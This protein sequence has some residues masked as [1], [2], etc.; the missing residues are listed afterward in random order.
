MYTTIETEQHYHIATVWLNRPDVRNAFNDTMI[1]E[2]I[3]AFETLGSDEVVRVITLRGRGKVF[4]A[5]ADLKWMKATATSGYK[6]SLEENRQLAQCFQT[7]YNT[8]KPTIAVVHGAAMG[9]A[10]GLIAACDF[11]YAGNDTL[12]AFSEVRLGLVPATIAPYILKRIGVAKAKELILTGR[13][14][15]AKEAAQAGLIN[16]VLQ[17]MDLESKVAEL[18]QELLQAGPES[19][20]ACKQLLHYL[21]AKELE[22]SVPYTIEAIARARSSAEGQ[23]GMQAFFEKRKPDWIR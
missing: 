21:S 5:G 23:E 19:I 2:L 6:E 13:Q 15:H 22:A 9:G 16:Q 3:H 10:N 7:V 1:A 14:F 11:A 20:A 17:E 12:F 8:P 18:I 4:C